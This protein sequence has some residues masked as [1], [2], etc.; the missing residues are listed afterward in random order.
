VICA[1]DLWE[2]NDHP[3][4]LEILVGEENVVL[5]ARRGMWEKHTDIRALPG[6][7]K[8]LIIETVGL[9]KVLVE[10]GVFWISRNR[11]LR[12]FRKVK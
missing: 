6:K 7:P 2:L 1:G 12:H 9:I 11:L 8:V 5:V 3:M 10:G 4:D